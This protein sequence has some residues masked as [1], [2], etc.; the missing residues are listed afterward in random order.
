MIFITYSYTHLAAQVL[1]AAA[2]WRVCVAALEGSDQTTISDPSDLGLIS[3][4]FDDNPHSL[5]L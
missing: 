2:R 5:V 4:L 1:G 3:V